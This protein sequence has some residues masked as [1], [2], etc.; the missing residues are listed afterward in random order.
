MEEPIYQLNSFKNQP[1]LVHGFSTNKIGNMSPRFGDDAKE[2]LAKFFELIGVSEGLTVKANLVHGDKIV[3]VSDTKI[4][5]FDC[6]ALVTDQPNIFLYLVIADCLPI[7]F[8]DP[9]G[10]V[11]ALAHCGWRG[12]NLHLAEK[13]GK[14]LI[15]KYNCSPEK[16]L[17]GFGPAIHRESFIFIESET[18]PL[19][20]PDWHPYLLKVGEGQIASDF[21]GYNF[22]QLVSLGIKKE[23]I[24][25]SPYDTGKSDLFYSHYRSK[26]TGEPEGRFVAIIGMKK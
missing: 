17:V 3:E 12:T 22:D 19:I 4:Q 13:V 18:S 15:E 16:I 25:V 26:R 20:G 10:K 5:E 8:F 1:N 21:V 2:S 23:N 14:L 11:V 7:M 24:E 9:E 6:D